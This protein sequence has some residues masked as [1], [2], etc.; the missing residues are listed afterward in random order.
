MKNIYRKH[1]VGFVAFECDDIFLV[2][3]FVPPLVK[4]KFIKIC[5]K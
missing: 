2:L 3:S 1:V 4:S 5:A